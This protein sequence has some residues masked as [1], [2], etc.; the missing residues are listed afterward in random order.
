M[1]DLRERFAV[2]FACRCDPAWTDRRLH[3]PDCVQELGEDAL[4][5]VATWLREQ[6]NA[7]GSWYRASAELQR[8]A[9]LISPTHDEGQTP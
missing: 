4:D 5:E 7:P 1:S 9:D 3:A 8:L 2:L 6:I